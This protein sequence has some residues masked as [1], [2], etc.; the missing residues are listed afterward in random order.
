M[1]WYVVGLDV[2]RRHDRAALTREYE[3]GSADR[4]ESLPLGQP[5]RALDLSMFARESFTQ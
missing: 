5:V 1:D 2:V 4:L 3:F